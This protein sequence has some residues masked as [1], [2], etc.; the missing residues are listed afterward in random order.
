AFEKILNLEPTLPEPRFWLA[1]AKE[2]DG[3]LAEAMVDYR[4][5]L[6]QAPAGAPWRETVAGRLAEVSAKVSAK[7]SLPRGG[8]P[9][10][11]ASRARRARGP[12]GGCGGPAKKL[13]HEG[14]GVMSGGMVDVWAAR[15][16]R[17]GNAL[18]GWLPLVNPSPT[19]ARKDDPRAALARAR[20]LFPADAK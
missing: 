7:V 5:L 19:L 14:R 11:R 10:P 17:D 4:A 16:K 1:L 20:L 12:P 6:A 2:Q 9:A 18:A 3:K 15:L 13:P 8:Q